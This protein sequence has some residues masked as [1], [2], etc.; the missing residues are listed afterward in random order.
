M[1]VT[2]SFE[3]WDGELSFKRK[4]HFDDYSCGVTDPNFSRKY[5]LFAKHV[6]RHETKTINVNAGSYIVLSLTP[7]FGAK[8][9]QYRVV[10]S[11][12][13]T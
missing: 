13:E 10:A 8:N 7:P 6:G 1:R 4:A 9:L 5:N 2:G 3:E 11:I 12:F